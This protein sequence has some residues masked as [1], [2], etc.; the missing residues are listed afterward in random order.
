MCDSAHAIRGEE[1][2]RR[3]YPAHRCAADPTFPDQREGMTP[4]PRDLPER[5]PPQV[6]LVYASSLTI[7]CAFLGGSV[8]AW[9][10]HSSHDTT[11]SPEAGRESLLED[12]WSAGWHT[13]LASAA[14][15]A[16]A[17]GK[18]ILVYTR[19]DLPFV[20]EFETAAGTDAPL[21]RVLSRFVPL[22]LDVA[23]AGEA[24]AQDLGLHSAPLFVRLDA[25]SDGAFTVS[26]AAET[27]TGALFEPIGLSH[28]LERLAGARSIN[29]SDVFAR[30]RQLEARGLYD[31]ANSLFDSALTEERTPNGPVHRMAL[32]RDA[33]VS[34]TVTDVVDAR[35][36]IQE[37]LEVEA[38]R[39]I[40]YQGWTTLASS[41]AAYHVTRGTGAA[42]G[43]RDRLLRR[44]LD[45]TRLG[46]KYA[47][48]RVLTPYAALLLKRYAL[49]IGEL[50]TMDKMFARAVSRTLRENAPDSPRIEFTAPFENR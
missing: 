32:L 17:S 36:A 5:Y 31:E 13:S 25:S 8:S 3:S 50:D 45:A 38:E 21:N 33:I 47:P 22:A 27:L 41:F 9:S 20:L 48:E 19:I 43:S 12:R 44:V 6:K 18:S 11:F 46:Y 7:L 39:E 49:D 42:A 34:H 16:E 37:H 29:P 26:G 1:K 4:T 24:D 30:I 23:G 14:R 35:Q 10:E 2:P 15:A 40:L 28:E